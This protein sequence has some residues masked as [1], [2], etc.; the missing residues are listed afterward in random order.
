MAGVAS[1]PIAAAPSEAGT[2]LP[3]LM[4][5]AEVAMI[6]RASEKT[7][8]RRITSGKL[9]AFREGGRWLIEVEDVRAMLI[10]GIRHVKGGA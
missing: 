4:T 3:Q 6:I 8:L 5:T 10:A 9:P 7:I 1:S 2:P